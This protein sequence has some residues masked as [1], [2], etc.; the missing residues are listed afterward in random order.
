MFKNNSDILL[1]E[2]MVFMV[3][4]QE[5]FLES[6]KESSSGDYVLEGIAAVFGKVNNNNRIYEEAEYL[7]HLDYLKDKINQ[8]RLLGELDH[9]EK[10]DVSLKNISHMITDLNYDKSGRKLL[11]KVQLLD[12]PAGQ[13]AKNLVDA[14]VPLSISSRA[15]VQVGPD[16]KVQIKK[17]FTYDLVADPGFENAQLKRVY[18]SAGF[19]EDEFKTYQSNSILNNLECFNESFGLENES[20]LKI[21]K[22]DNNE[23]FINL[24]NK[25]EIKNK[26]FLMENNEFVTSNELNQYS[27]LLKKEIDSIKSSITDIKKEKIE[28]SESDSKHSSENEMKLQ[29]RVEK[30]E[31]YAEYLSENLQNSISYGEYLAENLDN[32]ISYSKYLAENLDKN[33]SYSKYLAENVDKSISYSEYVAE[34]VDKNIE[35]SKYLAEKLDNNISYS[36]YLAENLDNGIAYSEYIAENLDKG[37]AYSEYIAENLEKGIS[38]TEYVAEKVNNGIEYTEYVAENLNKNIEYSDYLAEN[39]NRGVSYSEYIAEKLDKSISYSEYIAESFTNKIPGS[40]EKYIR[41]NVESIAETSLNESGF[42]G[43]Y[44][45]LSYKIDSLIESVNT[46]KIDQMRQEASKKFASPAETQK[47]N[48]R[49]NESEENQEGTGLKFIDEMPEE[50]SPIWESL[51]EGHKQSIVAQSNFYRLETAYQIKNFWATRQLG[52]APIG[53]QK[54]QENENVN[55]S[56]TQT[57]NAL[58]SDYMS[59]IA[60]QLEQRFPKR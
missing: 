58:P 40:K 55:V 10:F 60:S 25:T 27:I 37:I 39:I 33:I 49:L 13:I 5:F 44:G 3:E 1:N 42:A 4:K 12:T 7:P 6:K 23:E 57:A 56:E 14:G 50:Y 11:I 22:V 21:Y 19:T 9:P 2:Q 48:N 51:S 53:L 18:E 15:A 52:S 31:K 41:E 16:K 32:S 28:L 17:I 30:L 29:E 35:Y 43:D 45:N 20:A 54:I 59:Y 38:Y 46:Q 47:A 26:N 8:K 36:E 24:I 34:N